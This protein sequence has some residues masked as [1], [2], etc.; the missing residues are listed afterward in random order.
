MISELLAISPPVEKKG[1]DLLMWADEE[2]VYVE[3]ISAEGKDFMVSNGADINH[4][5]F[6]FEVDIELG[7]FLGLIPEHFSYGMV[8]DNGEVAKILPSPLH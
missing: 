1:L 7:E 4:E 6:I 3:A 5:T 2:D 8:L